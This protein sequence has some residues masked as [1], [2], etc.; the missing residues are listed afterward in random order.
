MA[1]N[2]GLLSPRP[3]AQFQP[4][5][6]CSM[7]IAAWRYF[8]D[9]ANLRGP[10]KPPRTTH[11]PRGGPPFAAAGTP[12]MLSLGCPISAVF[13]CP[14]RHTASHRPRPALGIH[15]TKDPRPKSPTLTQLRETSVDPSMAREWV[16]LSAP[17]TP[18]FR[19]LEVPISG[20]FL[21]RGFSL[22]FPLCAPTKQLK[23]V[24]SNCALQSHSARG[25]LPRFLTRW[26]HRL[27]LYL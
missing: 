17:G 20:L 1:R 13:V 7:A 11:G 3:A 24:G 19:S 18:G 8:S 10:K 4:A 12:G 21:L 5:H 6:A 25:P 16:C 15:S 27:A 23:S 9:W 14:L 2:V 26:H 22:S